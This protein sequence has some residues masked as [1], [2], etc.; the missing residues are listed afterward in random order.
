MRQKGLLFSLDGLLSLILVI[1]LAGAI[2]QQASMDEKGSAFEGLNDK[3]YDR[4]MVGM[5]RNVISAE[6][7]DADAE[8]GK[9]AVVYR[10]NLLANPLD[11][12]AVPAVQSFC[13]EA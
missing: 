13:E 12:P 3:A 1:V 11:A 9:C 10:Y 4:A 5:Y 6:T 8:F 2:V 7:I